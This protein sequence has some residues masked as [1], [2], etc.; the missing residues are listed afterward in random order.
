MV[1]VDHELTE[2]K[3]GKTR[4]EKPGD[5]AGGLAVVVLGTGFTVTG[6]TSPST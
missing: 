1:A 5:Q 6:L 2:A 4:F 3:D